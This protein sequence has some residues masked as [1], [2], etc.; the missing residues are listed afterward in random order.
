MGYLRDGIVKNAFCTGNNFWVLSI[1]NLHL[2]Y[3]TAKIDS[4]NGEGLS[5]GT[6][7]IYNRTFKGFTAFNIGSSVGSTLILINWRT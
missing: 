5:P 2:L 6:V 3:V 7:Y 1:N 4:N